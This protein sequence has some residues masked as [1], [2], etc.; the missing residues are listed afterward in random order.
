MKSYIYKCIDNKGF[1][2]YG[3]IEAS[4][5]ERAIRKLKIWYSKVIKII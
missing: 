5:K 3:E 4:S 1:P 2:I